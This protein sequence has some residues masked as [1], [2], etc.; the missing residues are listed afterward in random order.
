MLHF[1][2]VFNQT[3]VERAGHLTPHASAY[4]WNCKKKG[5]G[6]TLTDCVTLCAFEKTEA[7][8]S[9]LNFESWRLRYLSDLFWYL[10]ASGGIQSLRSKCV[11]CFTDAKE[12]K[13]G[14]KNRKSTCCNWQPLRGGLS[15]C[16]D[17]CFWLSLLL[18]GRLI[19]KQIHR[20]A[21]SHCLYTACS[22]SN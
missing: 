12:K 21:L 9:D 19:D 10:C 7:K 11:Q 13:W 22:S 1:P 5:G 16:T 4:H 2:T 17:F 15:Q 20:K 18:K 14:Q 8:I 3:W 6:S